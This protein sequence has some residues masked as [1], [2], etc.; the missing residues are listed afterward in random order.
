MLDSVTAPA[1]AMISTDADL[2]AACCRWSAAGVIGL[3]TEFIRE[4]TYFPRPAL[5]Q[6][7]DAQGVLLV[8]PT[9]ISDFGPL[10]E[11]L[12]D[13]AVALPPGAADAYDALQ[14]GRGQ[15]VRRAIGDVKRRAEAGRITRSAAA[16][17]IV[18]IV[19]MFG[20]R[21]VELPDERETIEPEDVGVV[22][23]MGVLGE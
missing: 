14:V 9:T 1:P 8:D 21:K 20:L 3:D 19:R 2:A 16:R 22:C 23:W 7:C 6:V 18:D 13:P 10:A 17:E 5:V 4:R 15:P 12:A 11:V